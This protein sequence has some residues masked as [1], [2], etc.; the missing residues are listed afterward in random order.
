MD[1]SAR[2]FHD[3]LG[4]K[5]E[6][7]EATDWRLVFRGAV[8]IMLGNCPSALPAS[9]T[10]DH[11]YFGYLEVDEIDVLYSEW[12][13]NGALILEPPTERPYGMREFTVSTPDG[14]RLVVGQASSRDQS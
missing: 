6:W 3:I 5:V 9:E 1:A 7:A 12:A 13:S 14:H 10:G 4:F 8:R 2:Y 11:N